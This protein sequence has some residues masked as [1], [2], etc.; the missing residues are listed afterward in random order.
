[1]K[2]TQIVDIETGK[3]NS[4]DLYLYALDGKLSEIVTYEGSEITEKW[5]YSYNQQGKETECRIYDGFGNM[6]YKHV[7]LYDKRGSFCGTNKY[8]NGVL[9]FSYLDEIEYYD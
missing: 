7:S 3:I 4:R 1:M 9:I 2:E 6:T 5:V 8:K